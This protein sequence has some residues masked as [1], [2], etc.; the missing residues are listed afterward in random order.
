M[1]SFVEGLKN[2]NDEQMK[3]FARSPSPEE[4]E[5]LQKLFEHQLEPLTYTANG[6]D[7]MKDSASV[8]LFLSGLITAS[9]SLTMPT[10]PR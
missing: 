4:K 1:N 10:K 3:H 5:V 7:E 2:H 9:I 8:A 6:L